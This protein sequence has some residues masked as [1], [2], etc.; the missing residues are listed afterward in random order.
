[1]PPTDRINRSRKQNKRAQSEGK[2]PPPNLP[3]GV[4]TTLWLGRNDPE[5]PLAWLSGHEAINGR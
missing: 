3:A 5:S 4:L 1:M 2:T